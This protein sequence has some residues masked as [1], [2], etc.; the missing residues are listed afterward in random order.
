MTK[1]ILRKCITCRQIKKR[2]DLVKITLETKTGNI[3]VNPDTKTFG[4]SVYLC[5][6]NS[7]INEALKKNKLE[8]T[9][10]TQITDGLKQQLENF[11]KE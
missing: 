3:I 10:K 4:R 5:Y 6:N 11:C 7:C 9:L 8:K 1:D 2:E